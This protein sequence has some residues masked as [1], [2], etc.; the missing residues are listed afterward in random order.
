MKKKKEKKR[1]ETNLTAFVRKE[2]R[3]VV[4]VVGIGYYSHFRGTSFLLGSASSGRGSGVFHVAGE[5]R[6]ARFDTS[7]TRL[8]CYNAALIGRSRIKVR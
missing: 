7:N 8:D 2:I 4:V 6:H 3:R 5:F 1:S